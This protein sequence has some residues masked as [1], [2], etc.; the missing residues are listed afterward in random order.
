MSI[1]INQS[2]VIKTGLYANKTAVIKRINSDNTALVV[3]LDKR[4]WE[5]RLTVS[6]DNLA[7]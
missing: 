5:I 6:F 7:S 1:Q 4:N 2:V 3:M